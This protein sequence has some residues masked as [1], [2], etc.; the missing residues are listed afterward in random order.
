MWRFSQNDK[1]GASTFSKSSSFM[2]VGSLLSRSPCT[3]D[4]QLFSTKHQ[5]KI[6]VTIQQ[7]HRCTSALSDV[8]QTCLAWSS[9][10]R[11]SPFQRRYTKPCFW[12]PFFQATSNRILR[13]P[14]A[15][16]RRLPRIRG[17]PGPAPTQRKRELGTA[18]RWAYRR[19]ELSHRAIV[20]DKIASI[21][22]RR[23]R[24]A[25]HS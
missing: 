10:C 23:T 15:S 20:E 18:A 17:E 19:R 2:L 9:A 16:S 5:R 21:N 4:S 11:L 14:P 25:L 7:Q 13:G 24:C 22:A 1:G 6:A 12:S 8:Q 3:D